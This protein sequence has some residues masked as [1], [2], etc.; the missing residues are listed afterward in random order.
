ME[1]G[2]DK[3]I[4]HSRHRTHDLKILCQPLTTFPRHAEP[5]GDCEEVGTATVDLETI[6]KTGRDLE[7]EQVSLATGSIVLE[8]VVLERLFY[9]ERQQGLMNLASTD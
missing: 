5:E 4:W 9:D 8:K 7:D 6:L 1:R 3:S 2:K